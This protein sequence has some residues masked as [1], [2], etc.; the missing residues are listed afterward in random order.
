MTYTFR[1]RPTKT[2]IETGM[3]R[4]TSNAVALAHSARGQFVVVTGTSGVGKTTT[5]EQ[6]TAQIN[7]AYED[8]P[9]HPDAYRARYYIATDHRVQQRKVGTALLQRRVLA[10]FAS[11]VLHLAVP[12]DV[13]AINIE[14]WMDTI[15]LGLRQQAV[16][17]VFVDEAGYLPPAA[18][19]CLA[20]LANKAASKDFSHPVTFVL[21]GMH[22]LP[23]NI[24]SLVNLPR[25]IAN[26]V[27]FEP[28]DAAEVQQVLAPLDPFFAALDLGTQAGQEIMEFLRSPEVS[29]GGLIGLIVPLVERAVAH[30]RVRNVPMD[31]LQLRVAHAS[32]VLGRTQ[33]EAAMQRGWK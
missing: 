12:S 27:T 33:S 28:C 21:V 10:E 3:M 26:W 5:A 13:R 20:T 2:I 31:L 32:K 4:Y 14:K 19:D 15:V 18:L 22:D 1:P 23:A 30:A 29:G 11:Q 9:D 7:A 17:M 16:Q 24:Q 25:R 6:I 8:D